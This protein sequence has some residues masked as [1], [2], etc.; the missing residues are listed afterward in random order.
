[1]PQLTHS[2]RFTALRRYDIRTGVGAVVAVF[3]VPQ[4]ASAEHD[5]AGNGQDNGNCVA[6]HPRHG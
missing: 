2:L 6:E 4:Q 3:F 5:Q 1:M